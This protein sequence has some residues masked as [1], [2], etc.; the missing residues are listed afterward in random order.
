MAK[1]PTNSTRTMASEPNTGAFRAAHS[2][3]EPFEV[4]ITDL[5]MPHVDGRSVAAAVKS[6]RPQT[7]VILPT[8]WGQRM[9]A[10]NDRPLNVNRVLA[11]PPRPLLLRSVLAELTAATPP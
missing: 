8:G 5:G 7:P 1:F 11:K 10:E 9:L 3:D 6:T 4:V 2:S